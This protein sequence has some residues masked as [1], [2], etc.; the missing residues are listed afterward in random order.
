MSAAISRRVIRRS[1]I[2]VAALPASCVRVTVNS[3]ALWRCGA[4]YYQPY[5]GRYVV[6]YV[7]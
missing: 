3:T 6:V 2:Y 5:H 4:T 7:N 1:T